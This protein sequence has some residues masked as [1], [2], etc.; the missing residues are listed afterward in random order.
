MLHFPSTWIASFGRANLKW[1]WSPHQPHTT[2]TRSL[3][4]IEQTLHKALLFHLCCFL[5]A[6]TTQ[7]TDNNSN[8]MPFMSTFHALCLFHD[9]QTFTPEHV[10][11]SVTIYL[12]ILYSFYWRFCIPETFNNSMFPFGLLQTRPPLPPMLPPSVRQWESVYSEIE[13]RPYLEILPEDDEDIRVRKLFNLSGSYFC[14]FRKRCASVC[15]WSIHLFPFTN[16][17][18]K[19]GRRFITQMA[20]T[21]LISRPVQ[22]QRYSSLTSFC[23]LSYQCVY[24][25]YEAP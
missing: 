20:A 2:A 6:T 5:V 1:R 13:Y 9:T 15:F 21:L 8:S 23:Y 14:T 19:G 17:R 11:H 3:L 24:R 18:H 7:D 25:F 10:H 22:A 12:F 16:T 4:W